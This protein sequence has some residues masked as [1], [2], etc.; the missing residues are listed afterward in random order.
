[1]MEKDGLAPGI[2]GA[3]IASLCCLGPLFIILF[4]FGGA[5]M[6]LSVGYR[7]PYFLVLGIIFFLVGFYYYRKKK[8]C[9]KDTPSPRSQILYFLGSFI[10]LLVLYYLLSFVLTPVLAPI[11]YK[12][13]FG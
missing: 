2:I 8:W 4:G 7:K 12:L 1:M 11:V 13:R 6:A 5:S 10:F 9:G 3:L